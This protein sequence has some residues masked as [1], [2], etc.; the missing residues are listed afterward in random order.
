MFRTTGRG[1]PPVFCVQLKVGKTEYIGNILNI[2]V[3]TLFCIVTLNFA[4]RH[5]LV[6]LKNRNEVARTFP[7]SL[8]TPLSLVSPLTS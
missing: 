4:K 6:Y 1:F 3:T 8:V 2:L 5:F 7:L